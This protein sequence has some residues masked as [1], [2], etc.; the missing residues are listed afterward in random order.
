[1]LR[2]QGR[3]EESGGGQRVPGQSVRLSCR[4]Y[5]WQAGAV[6]W[7]RQ[8]P[9]GSPDWLST[10]DYSRNWYGPAVEGRALVSRDS[11]RSEVSLSLGALQPQDS[12]RYFCAVHTG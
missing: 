8:A 3:L 7:Y 6:W 11:S 10:C 1:G 12:A 4:W 9:G 2:A 5:G